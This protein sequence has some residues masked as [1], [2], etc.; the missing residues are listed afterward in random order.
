MNKFLRNILFFAFPIL[1][2]AYPLDMAISNYFS[3]ISDIRFYSGE[4]AVWNDIFEQKIEA[5]IA[6]YGSSRAFVHFNSTLMEEKL[7]ASTYNLGVNGHQFW[8]QYLRHTLYLKYN[9]APKLIILSLGPHTYTK[10]LKGSLYNY[11][12]FLPYMLW[13]KE[14]ATFTAPY[15]VFEGYDY[16]LPLVRYA[17]EVNLFRKSL[18]VK[19]WEQWS[20]KNRV[21]GFYGK[22]LPWKDDITKRLKNIYT[23]RKWKTKP[24]TPENSTIT[25]FDQ[26][27]ADCKASD[28][29][30]LLVYSPFHFE[31][32]PYL[33]DNK[34]APGQYAQ[35]ADK[36]DLT[37]LNYL[38]DPICKD[39]SN[40]YN[41][42]HLNAKGVDLF[43]LKL[44]EDI[45]NTKAYKRLKRK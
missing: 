42:S 22:D 33:K 7:G 44:I 18:L 2:I 16:T 15:A 5:D 41:A 30:V 29:D 13:G 10:P 36:Y 35:F 43:T 14:I 3:G 25:L 27:L 17:G 38:D 40:F 20:Q 24:F 4:N 11:Q 19:R 32:I 23:K 37:F 45:K 31:S 26:F 28:I 34:E 9:P 12:Q 6:V 1:L 8:L 21:K 39:Q